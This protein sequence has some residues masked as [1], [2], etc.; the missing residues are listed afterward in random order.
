[1]A[2]SAEPLPASG[3]RP[4]NDSIQSGWTAVATANTA[5]AAARTTSAQNRTSSHLR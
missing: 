3:S 2:H 4:V 5:L 1:M